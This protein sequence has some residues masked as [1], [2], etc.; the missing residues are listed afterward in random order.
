MELTQD[1][2]IKAMKKA[3]E[4]G[5]LPKFPVDEE[6]YLKHWNGM[7]SVLEQVLN[8]VEC[9]SEKCSCKQCR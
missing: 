5:I 2:L 8:E 1:M 9:G 4:V 6:T 3:V 7:K